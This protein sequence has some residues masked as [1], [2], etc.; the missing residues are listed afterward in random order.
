MHSG[1]KGQ[2]LEVLEQVQTDDQLAIE[3]IMD[4]TEAHFQPS[5]SAGTKA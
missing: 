5:N 2:E 4:T 3:G 1:I